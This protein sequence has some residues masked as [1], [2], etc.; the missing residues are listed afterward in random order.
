TLY[1]EHALNGG[2]FLQ[3]LIRVGLERHFA[4]AAHALIRGDDDSRIA[5]EDAAHQTVRRETAENDGVDCADARAGEHGVGS[6]GDQLPVG[7][8]EIHVRRV[9]FP[10]DS[11]LIAALFEMAVHAVYA[12]VQRSVLEPFDEKIVRIE[13]GVL[14][15]RERLNPVDPGG[16]LAP[17]T[18]RVAN[19][20]LVKGAVFFV[21]DI[22][23]GAPAR[24]NWISLYHR[25]DPP[26]SV[27]FEA[28]MVRGRR[29]GNHA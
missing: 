1:D 29:G 6:F 27:K 15:L 17:E 7:D 16:L 10:E 24:R 23:R 2:T 3:R 8:L 19:A 18:V 22:R 28:I 11:H 14:D 21:V 26:K 13:G 5:I 4:A 9:A 12:N 20:P 25:L